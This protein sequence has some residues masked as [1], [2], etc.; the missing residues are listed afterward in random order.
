MFNLQCRLSRYTTVDLLSIKNNLKL[1]YGISFRI[2]IYK[3]TRMG[4]H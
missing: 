4:E 3:G 1:F 2:K